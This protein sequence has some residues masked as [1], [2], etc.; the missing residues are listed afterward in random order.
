MDKA[1]FVWLALAGAL[2]GAPTPLQ[3]QSAADVQAAMQLLK[4]KTA[5]LGT[6]TL[7]GEE[8]VEGRKTPILYFGTTRMNGD[9]ALVDAVQ[10]EKGGTATLF[11]KTG[12]DFVRIAT[13]VKKPDGS[14]AVGTILDPK[15]K[16]IAALRTGG[17]FAGEV[18]ILGKPYLTAYEPMQDARGDVIGIY[19]VGYLK[20]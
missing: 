4:A 15:G 6:P 2:A 19:Y 7:K 9:F 20:Q 12:E 16:A 3:A 8:E 13:N 14:R 11:V 10:K 5:Q 18:D 1:V 17:K